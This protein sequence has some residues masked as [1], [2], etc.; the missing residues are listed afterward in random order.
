MAKIVPY[1]IG[2]MAAFVAA[3]LLPLPSPSQHFSALRASF[4]AP[5]PLLGTPGSSVNRVAKRDR[6]VAARPIPASAQIATVEVIGLDNAAIVYRDR[7][8][9]ELFRTDPISN[10]TIVTNGLKLPEVTIR[11]YGGSVVRPVP[12][13]A[14][15]EP[16][17]DT[18]PRK[19]PKVPL[20][21]ESSFSSVAAPSLAHHLG[22]C[23]A[24]LDTRV[25]TARLD[26]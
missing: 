14:V 24:K 1:L 15:N 25:K 20:G 7:G 11:Q 21:C 4:A 22:R 18:K 16:A 10:V 26:G 12:V 3:D 2:G 23:M 13:D 5:A 8:G 9:R 17:N 19:R 6:A